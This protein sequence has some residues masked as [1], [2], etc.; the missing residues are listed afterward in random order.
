M[1]AE[2]HGGWLGAWGVGCMGGSKGGGWVHGGW[3]RVWEGEVHGG[4]V[5]CMGMAPR[6]QLLSPSPILAPQS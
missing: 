1:G 4:G 2:V 3:W 6:G 5:G